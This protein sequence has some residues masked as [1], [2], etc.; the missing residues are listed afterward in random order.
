MT[1]S[2]AGQRYAPGMDQPLVLDDWPPAPIRTERLVLRPPE[3]RDR[4]A[5][6]DLGSDPTVNHHLG[7]GRDRATLE[8]EL[9]AVPADRPAQFVLEH[10]G[11]FVG[12]MGL[13]RRAPT[14]PGGAALEGPFLELSYVL[15]V[16]AWGHGYAVEAGAAILAWSDERL[17]EPVV[18]CTQA[19]NARSLALAARLGFTELARFEEFDAEQWFGV[20][21][22][23]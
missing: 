23:G 12:W 20:R 22:P 13:G 15:P 21:V 19:A 3:A 8:A 2:C 16:A 4:E 18:V 6:L 7:G 10:D 14:R 5:F 1:S 9:P 11:R 17:G